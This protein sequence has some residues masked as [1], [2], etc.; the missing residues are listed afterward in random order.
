M[1]NF[2][3]LLAYTAVT[4]AAVAGGIA[5]YKKF[6]D[7]DN[8]DDDDFDDFEDD[9]FDDDFDDLDV[10]NR[11]YTSIASDTEENTASEESEK[12]EE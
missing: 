8:I 4:A 2:K 3:K 10:D 6:V 12:T 1:A 5:I 9:D 11:S 7:N